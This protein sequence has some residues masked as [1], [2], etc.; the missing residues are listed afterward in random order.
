MGKGKGV[1]NVWPMTMTLRTPPTHQTF[2]QRLTL[3]KVILTYYKQR[4][5]E[6]NEKSRQT[7]LPLTKVDCMVVLPIFCSILIP[8]PLGLLITLHLVSPY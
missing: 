3:P 2:V 5:T 6:G 1:L 4:H 8:F 7:I